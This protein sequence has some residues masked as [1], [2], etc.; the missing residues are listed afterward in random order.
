MRAAVYAR[1][2]AQLATP[3]YSYVPQNSAY[4]YIR[5]GD[6][7]AVTADTMTTEIQGYSVTIHSFDKSVAS[8]QPLEVIVA[9]IYTALHNYALSISGFNVI[10]CRQTNLNIFQQGDPNDR[11]WHAVQEFEIMVEDV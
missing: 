3:I 5:I 10:L 6:I 4:P 1:L 9:A 8:S 2:D 11:Y 7:S